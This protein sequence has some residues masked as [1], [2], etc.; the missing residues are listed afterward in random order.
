MLSISPFNKSF[1]RKGFT[2]GE[3]LLDAY[4]RSQV[5]Q[6]LRN[7][8]A[9]CFILHEQEQSQILGYYTL[10]TL[11]IE[12]EAIPEDFKKKL[13]RYP[14]VPM[15]LLGRLAVSQ[16]YKGNGF[17]ELLLISACHKSLQITDSI[18]AWAVAVDSLH[19]QARAF[20]SK[21][22]FIEFH[23]GQM[24]LTIKDIQKNLV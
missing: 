21:Y 14:Q 15:I 1:D 2:C 12:L 6:D 11:S 20:Y 19:D 23:E 4:I 24:F 9:S 22:G 7:K 8:V 3:P 17:G 13:P 10:S 16:A 5:S 18:G